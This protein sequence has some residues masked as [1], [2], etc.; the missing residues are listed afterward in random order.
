MLK[1]YFADP[2]VNA[3]TEL[4]VAQ[5]ALADVEH[6]ERSAGLPAARAFLAGDAPPVVVK[7]LQQTEYG[8]NPHVIK[9]VADLAAKFTEW[10]R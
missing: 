3:N 8:A 4:S 5:Q 7:L 2:L 1:S 6:E 10:S 9:F